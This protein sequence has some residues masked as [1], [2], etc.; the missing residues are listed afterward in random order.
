[1]A[2][3]DALPESSVPEHAYRQGVNVAWRWLVGGGLAVGV[4]LTVWPTT[5]I[6]VPAGVVLVT[7]GATKWVR[8]IWAAHS[9][10]R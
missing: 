8:S 7:I 3:G 4:G 2:I 10:S 1:V 9:R 5:F 6:L